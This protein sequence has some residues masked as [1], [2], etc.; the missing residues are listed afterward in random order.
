MCESGGMAI[1]APTMFDQGT[2]APPPVTLPFQ[3]SA[4]RG[5]NLWKTPVSLITSP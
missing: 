3:A 4:Q 1:A 2:A 5:I